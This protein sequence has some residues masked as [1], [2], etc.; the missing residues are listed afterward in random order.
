ML[1]EP[2]VTYDHCIAGCI[3]WVLGYS[4]PQFWEMLTN[5]M[6]GYSLP[7]MFMESMGDGE[8]NYDFLKILCVNVSWFCVYHLYVGTYRGQKK[9]SEPLELEL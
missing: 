3:I 8:K 5:M 7:F 9:V 2:V 6:V 4:Q 1:S